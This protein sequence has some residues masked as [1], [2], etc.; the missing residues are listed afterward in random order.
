MKKSKQTG[1]AHTVIIIVLVLALLG[2]LGFVFWQNFVNKP[3]T[4]TAGASST[5]QTA[6]NNKTLSIS[7]WGVKGSY[8]AKDLSSVS[9]TFPE[10]GNNLITLT[11]A[12]LPNN[13]GGLNGIGVI[14]RLSGDQPLPIVGDDETTQQA[15]Q[16]LGKGDAFVQVGDYYYYFFAPN[17]PCDPEGGTTETQLNAAIKQIV[18][19]LEQS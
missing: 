11:A 2:V 18:K 9:Y 12:N 17:A 4:K 14:Y 10:G 5:S 6:L 19:S 8:D 13:C 3:A 16:R 1:S 15:Y 7:V